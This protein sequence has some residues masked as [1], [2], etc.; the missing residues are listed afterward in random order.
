MNV[1]KQ[2]YKYTKGYRWAL[3]LVGII[4]LAQVA[5][6]LFLPFVPQLLID[7]IIS[8]MLGDDPVINP[9]N[10]FGGFLNNADGYWGMFFILLA[11][12]STLLVVRYLCHYIRWNVAHTV[13][14][15]HE[16]KM[17]YAAFDKLLSQ[18]SSVMRNYTSGDL[19]SIVN[20]D[21]IAV[22]NLFF[23]HIPV[24]VDQILVVSLAFFFLW[25]INPVLVILPVIIGVATAIVM[26]RYVR[27]MRQ[28]F[29]EIRER[30]IELN[31]VVTENIN[32][33]RIVRSYASEGIEEQKFGK[34]NAEYRKAFCKRADTDAKYH[35]IF[36][37][38]GHSLTL[39]S[40]ILGVILATQ[41][42]ISLGEYAT[43]VAYVWM[44]SAP[45]GLVA[46]IFGQMQN[47][48]VAGNRMFGF[49]GTGD[50]IASPKDAVPIT[51]SPHIR[52]EGISIS[53]EENEQ[54][55]DIDL[56]IPYGKTL[57]VMGR[58]GAGKT[59]LV[60]A[61]TRLHDAAKGA[62]YI[63]D[64]NVKDCVLEDV[65]RQYGIVFQEVFL[66][67]N[68]VDANIAFYSPEIDRQKVV[69]AAK[70]A[71]AHGFIERLMDGYDTVVGERGIGLSGGQKQRVSI[72]RALL[73]DAPVIVLD[74]STSALD[75]ATERRVFD[76]I[77]TAYPNKTVIITSHRAA[78]VEHC[79]EI[80]YLENGHI[81]ERGTH[82]ELMSLD[83]K[84]SKVYSQQKA[85]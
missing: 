73:K 80:V 60:K 29:N 79:D 28:R 9:N 78:S 74:D 52:L 24:V 44:I 4:G 8:P 19:M 43:F 85:S 26:V 83:G 69:E 49:I 21:P 32:G 17:R 30:S 62:V 45:I 1:I 72:A 11:I 66:F 25:I 47:A 84:Y 59:V 23:I 36:G 42:R 18:N 31:S 75:L 20:V 64:V 2:G 5:M 38:M 51:K 65:Y 15:L 57:G 76:N 6:A 13:G 61:L 16:G 82:E 12:F 81:T 10:P 56:D 35:A 55:V 50:Y 53:L 67:S 46:N 48:M 39:G 34:L 33:V 14:P 22:K 54:L 63:N 70:N 3:I 7:R 41:G 77:K 27:V 40:V 37:A 58:T 71:E 68:T